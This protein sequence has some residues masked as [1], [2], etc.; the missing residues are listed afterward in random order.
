MKFV[1][2]PPTSET[3]IIEFVSEGWAVGISLFQYTL[4]QQRIQ[5]WHKQYPDEKYGSIFLEA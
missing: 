3:S 5:L 1:Q 2:G 4:G